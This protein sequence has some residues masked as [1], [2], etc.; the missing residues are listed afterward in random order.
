MVSFSVWLF[1]LRCI[2][3]EEKHLRAAPAFNR[4]G[5][6]SEHQTRTDHDRECIRIVAIGAENILGVAK[7]GFIVDAD[8][9]RERAVDNVV[10]EPCPELDNRTA[11]A[12]FTRQIILER[13]NM[14]RF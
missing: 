4:G 3:W 8:I 6:F 14:R 2:F 11:R 1:E 10:A 5:Q 7:R 12:P 13:Q 9:G